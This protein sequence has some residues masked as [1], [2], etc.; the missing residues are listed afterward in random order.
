MPRQA[1]RVYNS[2][3]VLAWVVPAAR[4]ACDV[5]RWRLLVLLLGPL[6][7]VAASLGLA[8]W[9]RPNLAVARANNEAWIHDPV[10]TTLAQRDPGSRTSI[11]S[12]ALTK[13]CEQAADEVRGRLPVD[14]PVVVKAPLVLASDLPLAVLE[15]W[16][17]G[18]ILPACDALAAVYC[19][20][21]PDAPL[22]VYLCSNERVYLDLA[23]RLFNDEGVSVFGYFKPRERVLVLNIATGGGT[24]VHELTHALLAFDFPEVPDW[25]NEGL[26]S[27]HEQCRIGAEG[28]RIVGLIN[29]RLPVL[30]AALR[31]GSLPSLEHLTS[32]GVFRQGDEALRYAQ[33]RYLCLWMDQQGKLAT[34]YHRFRDTVAHD[35]QGTATLLSMFPGRSWPQVDD[36]FAA[37]VASLAWSP[38]RVE[39]ATTELSTGENSPSE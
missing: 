34:F 31:Q 27:L 4:S 24:L 36:Q 14:W 32:A 38:H 30:Q 9:V 10:G 21:R 20:R 1:R 28:Q 6:P 22:V 29:W 19:R 26:A 5:S 39:P 17:S 15:E 2:D 33:A 13:D 3:R 8:R 12:E 11:A 37:W 23:R 35:P 7:I 16:Y 18:T 25:F